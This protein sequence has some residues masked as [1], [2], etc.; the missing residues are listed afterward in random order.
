LTRIRGLTRIAASV[1]GALALLASPA[2]AV[3]GGKAAPKGSFPY[4][5]DV[6]IGGS[7]GCSGTLIAP[8]WVMTAGHCGSLTGSLSAG[9]APSQAAWP[10]SFYKVQL[11]S[12]YADG[13]GG[14]AH[15]VVEVLPDSDYFV[16]N[17]TG[18]DVTLLKLDHASRIKPILIA[19]VGE[20]SIW[21][22]GKLA[23]IAGFGT[24]SESASTPPPQMRYA[25]VPI[26]TDSYC[27]RAY[28]NGLSTAA[29]DGS[30]DA[31]SMLCAGYPKGGTDTCQGDSGGP[32]LAPL[33]N[34]T[35]RL[36]G[37]T[38]FG[39]G[40]AE[41]GKPGV[42][43]RLAEGP[44]R[45]FIAH[46]VPRALASEPRPPRARH[47]H[48]PSQPGAGHQHRSPRQSHDHRTS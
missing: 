46:Y 37:A 20:R 32:L 13:R 40:C 44:I 35:F 41:A 33:R 25:R 8:Q 48:P 15:S 5:A 11:G 45:A 26:T 19:A 47:G 4:V 22:P 30:F 9:L 28:P 10:A 17:G 29:N 2:A 39:A 14:E 24:T 38:S 23:T 16:T 7:F 6:L 27:A 21:R 36:V 12:V 43:A 1:C 31:K 34:G 3:V 42:Y 18:N